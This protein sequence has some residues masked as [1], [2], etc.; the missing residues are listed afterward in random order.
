M[1]D[2]LFDI[3]K[4]LPSNNLKRAFLIYQLNSIIRENI[5]GNLSKKMRITGINQGV[6]YIDAENS[7]WAQEITFQKEKI[8]ELFTERKIKITEIKVKI[9]PFIEAAEAVRNK[10]NTT[11]ESVCEICGHSLNNGK[12]ICVTCFNKREKKINFEIK[13]ILRVTP[14][15]RFEQLKEE[16]GSS[17]SDISEEQF[18]KTRELLRNETYDFMKKFSFQF[19]DRPT[20][21][22]KKELRR[23]ALFY[24][25]IKNLLTIEQ[26]NDKIIEKTL[27]GMLY[28]VIYKNPK[29]KAK[30]S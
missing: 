4:G 1:T 3:L 15:L 30:N 16:L 19:Y 9:A 27:G 23:R 18:I 10:N 5:S 21:K 11:L 8:K 13:K 2:S 26:I 28:N 29:N 7:A 6:V 12:R 22:L 20:E 25:M 17:N 24:T 14:W